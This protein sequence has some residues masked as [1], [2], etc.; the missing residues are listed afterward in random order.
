[1]KRILPRTITPGR[2]IWLALLPLILSGTLRA[3][4]PPR[5]ATATAEVVNGFLVG[6]GITDPGRGYQS[7]PSI[8]FVGGGGTGAKPRSFWKRDRLCEWKL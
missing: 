2:S 8:G 5:Q 1:M 4:G 7:V 6:V 3:D